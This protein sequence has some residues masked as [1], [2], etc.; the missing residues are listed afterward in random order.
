MILRALAWIC[1][2]G[3]LTLVESGCG[4]GTETAPP[5]L[6]I[7]TATLRDGMATFPYTQT[8]VANGGV[9]P[10]VWSVSSGNLPQNAALATSSADTVTLSGTPGTAQRAAFAIEVTDSRGQSATKNY[11]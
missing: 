4:G 6:S 11:V 10:F 7:S 2:A 8:I 3:L 5:T 1:I 9:T